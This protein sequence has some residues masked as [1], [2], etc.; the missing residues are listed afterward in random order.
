MALRGSCDASPTGKW[1]GEPARWWRE[2]KTHGTQLLLMSL[3][4][5]QPRVP[6]QAEHDCEV[7]QPAPVNVACEMMGDLT[8]EHHIDEVV[9][10][11]EKAH[12]T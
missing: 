11:L 9:E 7:Q 3:S 8:D 6:D 1:G 5:V 10:Q 2:S 12:L 4:A